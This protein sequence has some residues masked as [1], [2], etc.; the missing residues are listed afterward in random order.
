MPLHCCST[1]STIPTDQ[2]AAHARFSRP[3]QPEASPS[4]C[5][6]PPDGRGLTGCIVRCAPFRRSTLIASSRDSDE[7]P[8]RAF[9]MASELTR[10]ITAG[11]ATAVNIQRHPNCTFHD[12]QTNAAG[13]MRSG[14]GAAMSQFMICASRMPITTA[15]WFRLTRRPRMGAGLTSAM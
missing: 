13:D 7:Q 6:V 8:A 9:R 12:G 1:A 10:K 3:L 11:T 15:N 2:H 5:G 14:T 4:S